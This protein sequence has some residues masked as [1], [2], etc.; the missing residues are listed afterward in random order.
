[1][2]N[3]IGSIAGEVYRFIEN[4]GETS[5]S[6]VAKDLDETRSSVY[7]GIG[8]LAKEEKLEFD[9]EGRGT[10]IDLK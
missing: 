6:K 5:V 3:K 2:Q 1:M 9:S 7:M 4:N 10:S 8:W